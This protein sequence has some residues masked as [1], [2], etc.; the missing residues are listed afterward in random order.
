MQSDTVSSSYVSIPL[1][2]KAEA[3]S[4]SHDLNILPEGIH[5]GN[6]SEPVSQPAPPVVLPPY[7][8]YSLDRARTGANED[9]WEARCNILAPDFESRIVTADAVHM[10]AVY[11][12]HQG[13]AASIHCVKSLHKHLHAQLHTELQQAQAA[14][15]PATPDDV[16]E[17]ALL[18]AFRLT[19]GELR[20]M[21]LVSNSGSTATVALV[22][23]SNI[24]LAWVGDSRAVVLADRQAVACTREHRAD[25][26]PEQDRVVAAGGRV[27]FNSGLR[28]M[29]V[30][31]TTRAI[32]DYDLRSYGVVPEPEFINVPR[33]G[34]A[35]FLVLASDGL[36]DVISNEEV[37]DYAQKALRKVQ[38]K[39]GTRSCRNGVCCACQAAGIAAR[40]LA[41][42]AR[43]ERRSR[44]DIT[45]LLVNL[46]TPCSCA[47]PVGSHNTNSSSLV[48]KESKEQLR[49]GGLL[50]TSSVGQLSHSKVTP[51]RHSKSHKRH[52]S[53]RGADSGSGSDGRSPANL[54]VQA[55]VTQ[56]Q[57]PTHGA[58]LQ[59]NTQQQ[60]QH[61]QQTNSSAEPTKQQRQHDDD[62]SQKSG[63]DHCSHP[64]LQPS[65]CPLPGDNASSKLAG[66]SSF[67]GAFASDIVLSSPFAGMYEVAATASQQHSDAP[68]NG[69][70]A[71]GSS[72]IAGSTA[73]G[74]SQYPGSSEPDKKV[75]V[76]FTPND[77]NLSGGGQLA[78]ALQHSL[79]IAMGRNYSCGLRHS[80]SHSSSDLPV[81]VRT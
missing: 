9:A 62:S 7:G 49:S 40:A 3:T 37:Y 10:F 19:D 80:G 71:V 61:E 2:R 79:N 69:A 51:S 11:D 36:W 43:K 55:A 17:A 74:N 70:T 56:H 73:A 29:G 5:T 48:S 38:Q 31:A 16:M 35:E 27:F 45:V 34:G 57:A 72:T 47:R 12:G 64:C 13:D 18:Q 26:K 41:Q 15:L 63:S 77:V 44:D 52:N 76:V 68:D 30:L 60:Q 20:E 66:A 59:H 46:Q 22:T 54:A 21:P 65:V 81:C 23:P 4:S 50:C 58:L 53:G 78:G 25:Y 67:G 32:G 14:G 39:N 1:K 75:A 42:F 8:K 28:V 33:Q 6:H 24:H